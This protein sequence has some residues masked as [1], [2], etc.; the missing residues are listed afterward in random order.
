MKFTTAF[1]FLAASAALVGAVPAETNADRLARGLPPLPP[2]RRAPTPVGAK[3][4]TPSGSPNTCST[5]PVQC[6]NKVTQAND[7]VAALLIGLLGIIVGGDVAVGLTC[8]PLSVIGI[9]GNSCSAQTVCCSNNNF[10][11]L[12]AIG[13]TPINISL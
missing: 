13:C 6:C 5:G 4:S 1:A 12:I 7:P 3:R 11:G 9:G 10:N 8:S 2:T